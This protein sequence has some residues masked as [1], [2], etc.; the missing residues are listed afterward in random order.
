MI[1]AH[2]LEV[3]ILQGWNLTEGVH[4]H[5]HPKLLWPCG[6]RLSHEYAVHRVILPRHTYEPLR[7]AP[8]V[9]GEAEP[10]HHLP[11]LQRATH[12]LLLPHCA[13]LQ[14]VLLLMVL[15]LI[16]KDNCLNICRI[17]AQLLEVPVNDHT[18]CYGAAHRPFS[19]LLYWTK[20]SFSVL[21]SVGTSAQGN[22]CMLCMLS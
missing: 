3:T 13:H 14:V 17:C 20:S 22:G 8:M 9:A 6:R 5:V 21:Q 11:S 19:E 4:L 1:C 15:G 12:L 7:G 10:A 2:Q 16:V 18:S